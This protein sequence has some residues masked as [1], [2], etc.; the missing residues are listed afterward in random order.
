MSNILE[1]LYPL[2]GT[3]SGAFVLF[4]G[5]TLIACFGLWALYLRKS[6]TARKVEEVLFWVSGMAMV[7]F[8]AIRPLGVGRDDIAYI[9]IFNQICPI[10]TC[11]NW[12]QGNRDWGWYLLVGLLKSFVPDP[13]VMLWLA[14]TGLFA[15][16]YVIFKICRYPMMALLLY[17]GVFYQIQ[18]LTAFRVALSLTVFM[19]AIYV[20]LE[21]GRASGTVYL[22]LPGLFHK[23]GFLSIGLLVAPLFRRYYWVLATLMAVPFILLW[24]LGKPLLPTWF[25]QARL[26]QNGLDSYVAGQLAGA[27]QQ[28][29]LIPLS[30]YPLGGLG[31]WLAKDVFERNRNVYS[32]VAASMAIACWLMWFFA[33]ITPVQ[34]R[35]FEYFMLPIVLLAGCAKRNLVNLLLI[36]AVAGS[37]VVRHNIL[38]QLIT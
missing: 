13:K 25:A 16:L 32:L 5:S 12:V 31:L 35:F 18:D 7:S 29:K 24:T 10:L 33:S 14:A 2:K 21:R 6:E 28:D 11:G 38:N 30:L 26:A 4:W 37:W 17:A 1:L 23:Q 34:V 19:L 20:W 8:A 22:V 27:F 3:Y 9:E 36:A 15:K